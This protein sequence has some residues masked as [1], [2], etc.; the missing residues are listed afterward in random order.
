MLQPKNLYRGAAQR[1]VASQ[2][3]SGLA[4]GL[5]CPTA[6]RRARLLEDFP[7]K[8]GLSP[9]TVAISATSRHTSS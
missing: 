9:L 4:A 8:R 2:L 3:A 7:R 6:E 1:F 5:S